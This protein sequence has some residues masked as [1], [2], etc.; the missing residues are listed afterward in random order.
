[1][2]AVRYIVNRK[3][4]LYAGATLGLNADEQVLRMIHLQRFPGLVHRR[5]IQIYRPK[6]MFLV[7]H[8][9]DLEAGE[10]HFWDAARSCNC[11]VRR[12]VGAMIL[13][14]HLMIGTLAKKLADHFQVAVVWRGGSAAR[15]LRQSRLTIKPRL[16]P[17]TRGT[18]R[19]WHRSQELGRRARSTRIG[20]HER[21][22]A[23]SYRN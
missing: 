7:T 3:A 20:R 23:Q 19:R 15:P 6:R 9:D 14:G 22:T 18:R 2:S 13:P 5:V 21:D 17:I 1:M 16:G 10:F 4:R 8:V 11:S 12:V